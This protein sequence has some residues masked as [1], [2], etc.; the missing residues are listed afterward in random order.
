MDVRR[1]WST[2]FQTDGRNNAFV[3]ST[4]V[5]LED[6]TKT[7]GKYIISTTRDERKLKGKVLQRKMRGSGDVKIE[8]VGENGG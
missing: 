8:M 4:A 1:D 2:R 5:R 7:S 6:Y 3:A